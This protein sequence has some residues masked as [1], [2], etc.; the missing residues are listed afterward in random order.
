RYGATAIRSCK[1]PDGPSDVAVYAIGDIQ[2]CADSLHQLLER[3][4]F[5]PGRDRLWFTGDLVNRGPDS[6][7]VL[8]LVKGLGARVVTVLGNHDLHLLAAWLGH[9]QPKSNDTIAQVLAAPDADELMH[10]LRMQPLLHHDPTLGYV[11]THAGIAPPW[12]LD[13]AK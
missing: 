11:M 2:G 3:V 10:W 7:A 13:T 6:L 9:V 8:R 4:G 12:D 1:R 5:E